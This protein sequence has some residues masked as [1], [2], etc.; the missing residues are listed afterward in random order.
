M[1]IKHSGSLDHIHSLM[2]QGCI[3]LKGEEYVLL[4]SHRLQ[5]YAKVRILNAPSVDSPPWI[6]TGS[7]PSAEK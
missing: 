4:L 5:G 7:L 2:K 6:K 1:A 3:D